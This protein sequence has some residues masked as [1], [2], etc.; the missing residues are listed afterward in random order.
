MKIQMQKKI[1]YTFAII[2]ITAILLAAPIE[3]TKAANMGNL[4]ITDLSGTLFV[5]K[6]EDLAAMPKTYV[7][8]DLFCYGYL[9]D[10]GNWGGIQLSY[11]LSQ[12]NFT[13]EVGSIRFVASDGYKVIIPINLALEPQVIVAFEKDEQE[14]DEGYRLVLPDLNGAA[15]IAQI[16]SLTMLTSSANYPEV[17]SAAPAPSSGQSPQLNNLI[18]TPQPTQA[19]TPTAT[20]TQKPIPSSIPSNNQAKTTITPQPVQPTPTPQITNS[21]SNVD[22]VLYVITAA[23]VVL[24]ITIAVLAIKRKTRK[25]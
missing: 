17:V 7:Y 18:T 21:N 6:S 23:L 1:F 11:L 8:S 12:A 16:T 19:P 4:E 2:T 3:P 9:V 25:K 10:T 20:P 14:L 22:D 15:W 13:A 24:S 5:L